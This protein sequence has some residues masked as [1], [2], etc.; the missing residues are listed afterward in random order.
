MVRGRRLR[1]PK[2]LRHEF[3]TTEIELFF[4]RQL[5]GNLPHTLKKSSL[6]IIT[7]VVPHPQGKCT[8]RLHM[9]CMQTV[10]GRFGVCLCTRKVNQLFRFKR[11]TLL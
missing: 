7:S 1:E 4:R 11:T 8:R 9:S 5:R 10:Y 3:R 6:T 2:S